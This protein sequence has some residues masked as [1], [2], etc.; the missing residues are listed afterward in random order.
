MAH[1]Q[2]A[3]M[4]IYRKG[5]HPRTNAL[6]A[7]DKSSTATANSHAILV[8]RHD[9]IIQSLIATTGD[10]MEPSNHGLFDLMIWELQAKR[11]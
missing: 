11:F 2:P 8:L 4:D 9:G 7:N 6:D 3:A 5:T 1:F 10:L